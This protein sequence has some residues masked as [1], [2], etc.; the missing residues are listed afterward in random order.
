VAPIPGT[1]FLFKSGYKHETSN[2]IRLS[3]GAINPDKPKCLSKALDA[4]EKA[5]K[6]GAHR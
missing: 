6:T 5:I 1:F 3:L 4:M 2:M